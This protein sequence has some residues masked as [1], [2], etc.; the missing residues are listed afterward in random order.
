MTTTERLAEIQR[1]LLM[2]DAGPQTARKHLVT[3]T[4]MWGDFRADATRTDLAYK[5][6]LGACRS[7]H[8]SAADARM[9]AEASEEYALAR[10]AKDEEA[11][12]LELIRSCKAAMRSIDEEMRLAR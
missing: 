7:T 1:D 8:K 6:V 11:F 3:L 5:A 12:C 9:A 4:A 10:K 2:P